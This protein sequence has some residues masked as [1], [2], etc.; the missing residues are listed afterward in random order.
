MIADNT[1]KA[2]KDL[3]LA[4]VLKSMYGVQLVRRGK[5]YRGPCPFHN[6]SRGSTSFCVSPDNEYKCFNCGR[7]GGGVIGFVMDKE[8]MDFAEAVKFI[9]DNNNIHINY[10]RDERSDAELAEAKRRESMLIALQ[11]AQK[12]FVEQF[13]A[14]TPEAE[15]ARQYAYNRWGKEYCEK[16]GVGYAP[17]D[18]RIFLGYIKRNGFSLDAFLDV[19][20]LGRN[21]E[22]GDI[23]TVLRWRVTLP[24]RSRSKQVISYS[25]RYV[26]T[27]EKTAKDRKYLNLKESPVFHKSDTLFGIDVA[28]G[29]ARDKGFIVVEGGPDVMRLQILGLKQAVGTMGTALTEG[30]LK[31]MNRSGTSI[32]F[33][34]DSDP[35]KGKVHGA[36]IRAVMRGGKLAM[37]RGFDVN[38]KEIPR[39]AEDDEKEVKYDADSY[40]TDM[41][42]FTALDT[43]PFVVWYAAK[44]LGEDPSPQLESEVIDEVAALLLNVDDDNLREIFITKLRTVTGTAKMWRDA[45]KRAGRRASDIEPDNADLPPEIAASLRRCGLIVK[46]GCYNY[47][48]NDGNLDVSTNFIIKPVLHI[49]G[50]KS[51]RILELTNTSGFARVIQ[52]TPGDLAN[53]RDF[54][55]KI[56][57]KGNFDIQGDKAFPAIVRHILDVTPAAES[58]DI[59]GWD[60]RRNFYAFSNGL[61]YKGC[62]HKAD[63]LGVVSLGGNRYFLPAFSD[64]Y[65]DNEGAYSFEKLFCYNSQGATSL[66]DLVAAIVKVYGA[67]GMVSFAWTLASIFRDIIFAQLKWFPMLNLFGRKGSGKTELARTLSSLFY[68]LPSSPPSLSST[69][70]PTIG[71]NLSH[72]RDSVLILDEFTNDLMPGRIDIIKNIWGGNLRGRMV[73][74]MPDSTPVHTGLILAG[75]YKPEDEAIFSRCI[76]L[77]YTKDVFTAEE[78]RNYNDL[79]ELVLYGNTHLLP[80]ILDLR[81]VF[82][83]GFAPAYDLSQKD[84][85]SKLGD[86]KVDTRIRNNWITA[87]AAFRVIEPHLEL[88][89]NYSDLLKVVVDGI[90]YQND[91]IKKSSDTANFWNYL[92]AMHTQGKAQERCH[93]VIKTQSSFK[94]LKKKKKDGED[95]EDAREIRF[96]TPRRIVYLNFKAVRALLETRLARQKYGSTLD[97]ATLESY[98]KSMPQFMGMKQQRF[99]NLRVNGELNEEFNNTLGQQK[100]E[101]VGSTAYAMCFD[102]D[103]LKESLDLSLETFRFSEA[104]FAAEVD[105]PEAT[106]DHA[107]PEPLSLFAPSDKEDLPF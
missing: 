11:V 26:G 86:N 84:V 100:R 66:Y 107:Q 18:G 90:V 78:D 4:D 51:L 15:A 62:F 70:N 89:F 46:K 97:I 91:Q 33:I 21:E 44:R 85:A 59:L 58:I 1:I 42:V 55:K 25:A 93:F 12:F 17:R 99:Q 102:Y 80:S 5:E 20:L 94:P 22:T 71:Y 40:I 24:I 83:D 64:L 49:D 82:E 74:G 105:E 106:A 23:Y 41:S 16:F 47:A 87:L 48:D 3:S 81:K 8:G 53:L 28:F 69:S 72:V 60:P 45:I 88:P 9:A 38:V 101:M 19:G 98:L 73:E 67:G 61:Y 29:E 37:E 30:Q 7:G 36:G 2:V 32:C 35:P 14:D 10:E 75:Q 54:K 39:T 92:D 50:K 6:G 96:V 104:E 68:V 79:K 34:P 56:Y 57:E 65:S 52:L 27:D 43:Q 77:V 63:R 13:D 95:R 76:H 31:L 103:S